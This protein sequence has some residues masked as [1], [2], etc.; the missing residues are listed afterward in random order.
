[1]GTRSRATA[2][3]RPQP[4]LPGEHRNCRARECWCEERNL[5]IA[6]L[7]SDNYGIALQAADRLPVRD[8]VQAHILSRGM[9]TV[10]VRLTGGCPAS[11]QRFKEV[12]VSERLRLR[13]QLA[14]GKR[15]IECLLDLIFVLRSHPNENLIDITGLQ[16][17][18]RSGAGNLCS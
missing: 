1:M 13:A 8:L 7:R 6:I 15:L 17:S 18:L 4:P 9:C 16:G 10:A 5:S 11:Y 12:A 14:Y 3:K 2:V